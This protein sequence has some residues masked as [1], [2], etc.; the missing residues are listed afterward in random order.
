MNQA[1]GRT[2]GAIR[3]SGMGAV[4]DRGLQPKGVCTDRLGQLVPSSL[5]IETNAGF[6]QRAASEWR[7]ACCQ[8]PKAQ[9][10]RERAVPELVKVVQVFSDRFNPS[11]RS[12]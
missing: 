2:N 9:F 1:F 4:S 12:L 11:T 8:K 10:V 3:A 5:C 7:L 6:C